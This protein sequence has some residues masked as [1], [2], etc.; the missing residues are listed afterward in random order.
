MDMTDFSSLDPAMQGFLQEAVEN[1]TVYALQD[2][3]GWALTESTEDPD[4]MVLPLWSSVEG[5]DAAATGEWS[6][7]SSTAIALDELLEDWLPGLQQD[8]LRVGVNWDAALDGVELP[9]LEL[10]A[11]LEAVIVAADESGLWDDDDESD[12]ASP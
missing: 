11:D 9:P 2:D 5:A 4:V 3:E 10:Q 8:G 12:G 6:I 1:G 7:Y